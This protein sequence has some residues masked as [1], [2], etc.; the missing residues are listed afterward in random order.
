MTGRAGAIN[1]KQGGLAKENDVTLVTILQT[2]P[3]YVS[4][5]VPENLLSRWH[6]AAGRTRQL[7]CIGDSMTRAFDT[8]AASQPARGWTELVSIAMSSAG[9]HAPQEGFRAL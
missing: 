4:F 3:I 5:A 1:I 7:V 2:A 6:A 9:E 8:G